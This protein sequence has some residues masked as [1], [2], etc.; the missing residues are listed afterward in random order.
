MKYVNYLLLWLHYL[1]IPLAVVVALIVPWY[2]LLAFVAG[3]WFSI[4]YFKGCILTY[5][6]K[7]TRGL[8]KNLL[9]TQFWFYKIFKR[10]ISKT[11]VKYLNYLFNLFLIFISL[12]KDIVR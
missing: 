9:F 7:K 8:H 11:Q 3:Y 2:V 5:I 12:I 1:S 4:R 6:Q 10:E